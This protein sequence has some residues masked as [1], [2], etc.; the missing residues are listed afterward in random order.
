MKT[1]PKTRAVF[2]YDNKDLE[3]KK[4]NHTKKAKILME[5]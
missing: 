5:I 2:F 4:T 3:H 1:A